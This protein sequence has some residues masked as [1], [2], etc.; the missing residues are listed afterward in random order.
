LRTIDAFRVY[1]LIFMMTRGGPI[2]ATDT[3]SWSV[4]NVG[5][6]N[7]NMGYA[8]ALSWIILII[9]TVIVTVFIRLLAGPGEQSV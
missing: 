5:F 2:N 8:A 6:R 7:F 4:Y 9:V 3:L 1:D